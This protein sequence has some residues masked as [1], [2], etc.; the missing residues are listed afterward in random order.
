MNWHD[1]AGHIVVPLANFWSL[2]VEEQFYLIWPLIVFFC[3]ARYFPAICVMVGSLSLVLRIAVCTGRFMDNALLFEWIHRSTPARLDTLAVGALVAVV[4]R[5]PEWAQ[6]A[7]LWVKVAAPA[8]FAFFAFVIWCDAVTVGRTLGLTALAI[9]FGCTVLVCV[10]DEGSDHPLCRVARIGVLR[11]MGRYSYAMYVLHLLV[12]LVLQKL[13]L[14]IGLHLPRATPV[15]LL[16][17]IGLSVC[18]GTSYFVAFGSWNLLEKHFL[19]M[20]DR[21]AYRVPAQERSAR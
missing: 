2:G 8:C 14:R 17:L 3:A 5:C 11:S 6:R 13:T 19:Q 1:T 20:K 9:G 21:F 7:Q 18:L 10:M 16:S 4:I 15:L 12:I